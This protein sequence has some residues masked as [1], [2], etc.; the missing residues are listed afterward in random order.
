[1][2]N[3]GLDGE[4]DVASAIFSHEQTQKLSP[5]F[6]TLNAVFLKDTLIS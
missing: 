1:M 4:K 6:L 3:P 5:V 2:L